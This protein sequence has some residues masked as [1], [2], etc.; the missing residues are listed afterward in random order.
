MNYK[1]KRPRCNDD[2][3]DED[4]EPTEMISRENNHIYFYSDINRDSIYKL[5]AFIREAERFCVVTALEI[6]VESMPIYLHINSYGGCIHSAFAAI[7]AIAGCR[8]PVHSVI[9]GSTASAGTLI[10]ISCNKRYI[11]KNAYMLIHQLSSTCWGKMSEIDDEYKN[12][13]DLMD[14][15]KRIYEERATISKKKLAK[16]LKRDLWLDSSVAIANGLADEI[17]NGR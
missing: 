1:R 4:A 2:E 14:H 13:T 12:L 11:R 10:S 9:E 7:D 8:V 6:S 5:I 3:E 17:W 16:L 15:V